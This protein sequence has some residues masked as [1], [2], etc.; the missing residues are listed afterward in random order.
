MAYNLIRTWG[1]LGSILLFTVFAS[2]KTPK[3]A[4][5]PNR[6]S[7]K[8]AIVLPPNVNSKQLRTFPQL[9]QYVQSLQTSFTLSAESNGAMPEFTEDFIQQNFAVAPAMA[10]ARSQAIATIEEIE[11]KNRFVEI[12]LSNDL[13]ELPVGMK[14]KLG[15]TTVTIGVSKAKFMTEYA[16]LTIFCKVDLPQGKSILF[17]ADEVKL[18]FKG[19]LVGSNANLVLLG[20]FQIPINGGNTMLTLK[21]GQDMK[22]GN[23]NALTYVR[24]ECNGV[25]ELGIAA[26]VS[27]PRSLI[28]PV[29]SDNKPLADLSQKV[30]GSF[31]TV[32]SDWNDIVADVTLPPFVLKGFSKVVFE[33]DKAVIDLSDKRNHPLVSFPAGYTNLVQ[34]QEQL[35]RGVYIDK[36]KVTLPKEFVDK[37]KPNTPVS[38]DAEKLI[39]DNSGITGLIGA[40]N[41]IR[42]G[43]ASGWDFSVNRF[44]IDLQSNTLR[45]AGFNGH[46]AIPVSKPT[47]DG[48]V[49]KYGMAYRAVFISSSDYLLNVSLKDTLAFDIWKAKAD[50]LPGSYV[51][52]AVKDDQFRPKAVLNGDLK[53]DIGSSIKLGKVNFQGLTLQTETPYIALASV[54]GGFKIMS[55]ADQNTVANFPI[56]VKS[57]GLQIKDKEVGLF[58][59]SLSLQFMDNSQ[60]ISAL[61][62]VSIVGEFDKRDGDIVFDFKRFDITKVGIKGDFGGFKINGNVDIFK[63]DP[64]RGTGFSGDLRL[65][66]KLAKDTI[67]VAAAAAFG[68]K[69]N[70]YRYWYVDALATGFKLPVGGAFKINGIGGGASYQMDRIQA[71]AMPQGIFTGAPSGVSYTPNNTYGVGFRAMVTFIVG[72]ESAAQGDVAL[73]MLFNKSAGGLAR[74]GLYGKATILPS[75]SLKSLFGDNTA[76]L[77]RITNNYNSNT[78][79]VNADTAAH[80]AKLLNGDF[81]DLGNAAPNNN[82]TDAKGSI[83]ASVGIEYDFNNKALDARFLITMNIAEGVII[84]GGAARM[85]FSPKRWYVHLGSSERGRE[86]SVRFKFGLTAETR[87]YFMVGDSIGIS[88]PP[89]SEVARILGRS[90][91]ELDYMRDMNTLEQGGGFAFGA[92]LSANMPRT[93]FG[94]IFKLYAQFSAGIGFD[95]MLKRYLNKQGGPL[96]CSNTGDVVGA[97]GW[98][99]NGQAYAYL[100]GA[101]GISVDLFLFKKDVEIISAGAAVLLQAKGPNPTWFAGYLAG[102]F[103]VLGGLVSGGFS[104]KVNFG[105]ECKFQGSDPISQK[106]EYITKLTPDDGTEDVNPLNAVQVFFKYPINK[107]FL[108]NNGG[109]G[110]QLDANSNLSQEDRDAIALKENQ[111]LKLRANIV[112]FEVIDKNG[113]L[114]STDAIPYTISENGMSA[115][116][117]NLVTMPSNDSL[118]VK[119]EIS[120]NAIVGSNEAAMTNN[121]GSPYVQKKSIVFKTS[122]RPTTIPLSNIEFTYPVIDQ[123]FFYPQE[124]NKGF[125]KLRRNQTYLAKDTTTLRLT[126]TKKD[127]A[128]VEAPIDYNEANKEFVFD[129]PILDKSETYTLNIDAINKNN[130]KFRSILNYKFASSRHNTFK[131]KLTDYKPRYFESVEDLDPFTVNRRIAGTYRRSTIPKS[132]KFNYIGFIINTDVVEIEPFD[133]SELKGT[134]T[135]GGKPLINPEAIMTDEYYTTKIEPVM[136]DAFQNNFFLSRDERVYGRVP[137]K[138]IIPVFDNYDTTIVD[139][140]PYVH[141]LSSVYTSDFEDFTKQIFSK[142]YIDCEGRTCQDEFTEGALT[143]ERKLISEGFPTMLEGKYDVDF[144]YILPNGEKTSKPSPIFSYYHTNNVIKAD[145]GLDQ[146]K[147]V[148]S[149]TMN[150]QNDGKWTIVKAPTGFTEAN[151]LSLTNRNAIVEGVPLDDEVTLRWS[152]T[153]SSG[154]ELADIVTLYHVS[155]AKAG[156]DQSAAA[157]TFRLKGNAIGE[158]KVIGD[159][160]CSKIVRIADSSKA[161]TFVYN[162]PLNT[163]VTL[164]WTLKDGT[165]TLYD[166]VVLTSQVPENMAGDDI[167]Q[168]DSTFVINSTY[169]KGFWTA[170]SD[171]YFILEDSTSKQTLLTLNEPNKPL[172]LKRVVIDSCGQTFTDEATL[173]WV[174]N[175]L[176]DNQCLG[177][178]T[179][180]TKGFGTGTWS[181]D[182]ATAGFT[183]KV[184][185]FKTS[186]E[187]YVSV[188]N[189]P[190]SRF[191]NNGFVRLKWTLQTGES[192][193]I[194]FRR[195][196][197]INAGIDQ[198]SFDSVF[199]MD[200][201]IGE[202]TWSVVNP[203]SGFDISRVEDIYNPKTRVTVPANSKVNLVWT[204]DEACRKGSDTVALTRKLSVANAGP[205]IVGS[206]NPYTM[207][208]VGVGT[209]SVTKQP[210]G[211]YVYFSN[212][213]DPKASV[214]I[215]TQADST[216]ALRWTLADGDYDD[217]IVTKKAMPQLKARVLF[218][219]LY[220]PTTGLMDRADTALIR[221]SIRSS[222]TN[223]QIINK[224]MNDPNIV[225]LVSVGY[226]LGIRSGYRFNYY[227]VNRQGWV[228]DLDDDTDIFPG[229]LSIFDP[230]T[231]GVTREKNE[232]ILFS[233]Y[234][235]VIL[236]QHSTRQNFGF[237]TENPINLSWGQLLTVDA[238]TNTP[239]V[240][241][242]ATTLI[243]RLHPTTG[244]VFVIK[245]K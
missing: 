154:A 141:A 143:W 183:I 116:Y 11:R 98:Y 226:S 77:S 73:E 147:T 161:E 64:N 21:G 235:M 151:I 84:G 49:K 62:S 232:Q 210:A 240:Y 195:I 5:T 231:A 212:N 79:Q 53:V 124:H 18:S 54:G 70:S 159:D 45:R 156:V 162:M 85:H 178:G 155:G 237:I 171:S 146:V 209:W 125:I 52:L 38:F 103:S 67:T 194:E 136:T 205:D 121:D 222:V 24:F 243:S 206:M 108:L 29:G 241:S 41:V 220:N 150:A 173:L 34:G 211:A 20:D 57:I 191:P 61:T 46:I 137:K 225:G 120:F 207:N 28:E 30:T 215:F 102:R 36:L 164:R 175:V 189:M 25:K 39:V 26:D 218:D 152:V 9:D 168:T 242:S 75:V 158:W 172:K 208:A 99:A 167:V 40:N 188:I 44:E 69:N 145:A 224:L 170:T 144:K 238:T 100:Q 228:V 32:V 149:F 239:L 213:K 196:A 197:S 93:E 214:T 153:H 56:V 81:K 3:T 139:R 129:L 42:T 72:T 122:A 105:E 181:V 87:A 23:V 47:A 43:S 117:S 48:D 216:V 229:D 107:P 160:L 22:T 35:W 118:T 184:D 157:D 165:G 198:I 97:N 127:G 101:L 244:S 55:K 204:I 119:I 51:E 33:I 17:G 37:T 193:V 135:T 180:T 221:K 163:P 91:Q 109:S 138:A 133:M 114:L 90:A 1:M 230:V 19:G 74:I 58:L 71:G 82:E 202:G 182:G 96:V 14:K 140:F 94:F 89:P 4:G 219:S 185:S 223:V 166:D 104:C 68:R 234:H 106:V 95:I 27:F 12:L 86:L 15:N 13:V 50:I 60:K 115:E 31:K 177:S 112:K 88:P 176:G 245:T 76:L 200:A 10:D 142:Y 190:V 126:F 134:L 132:L 179:F 66:V 63:D 78:A 128:V 186:P 199:T 92:H 236:N 174:N 110:D 80:K 7:L 6:D 201:V 83:F 169:G 16:L 8:K 233:S 227:F 130:R 192:D 217:M 2:A 65:T 187:P 59:D 148:N 111:Q 123:K 203:T 131:E 113:N